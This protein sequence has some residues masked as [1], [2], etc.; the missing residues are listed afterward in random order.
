MP[1]IGYHIVFQ[2]PSKRI[3]APDVAAQ[4]R[5]CGVVHQLGERRGVVA[6]RAAGDHLHVET[7]GDRDSAGVLAQATGSALTQALGLP[8]FNPAYFEP[9]NDNDHLERAFFYILRNAE[10]HGVTNDPKHEASSIQALLGLRRAPTTFLP[11]VRAAFPTLSRES[12]VKVLGLAELK[13]T[14]LLE[15]LADAAAASVGLATLDR[16]H[17]AF[18]ARASACRVANGKAPTGAVAH[19]LG[20]SERTVRRFRSE[21]PDVL[22]ERAIAHRMGMTLALG[23]TA[24][25]QQVVPARRKR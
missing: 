14:F 3:I 22:L 16:S 9:I 23:D 17:L 25:L 19:A 8:G 24:R 7:L 15:D 4:R 12:L 18:E 21:P 13:P 1:I 6:F 20:V 10:K 2:T 5:L 11:R